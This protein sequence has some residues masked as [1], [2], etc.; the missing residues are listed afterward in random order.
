MSPDHLSN[1]GERKNFTDGL[2]VQRGDSGQ[3]WG[4]QEVPKGFPTDTVSTTTGGQKLGSDQVVVF[5]R[6]RVPEESGSEQGDRAR[7]HRTQ[8]INRYPG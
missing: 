5:V 1:H 8:S 6:V 3:R 2:V 7:I 4:L